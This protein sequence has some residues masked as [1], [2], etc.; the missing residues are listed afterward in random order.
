MEMSEDASRTQES[1]DGNGRNRK[2]VVNLRE[3]LVRFASDVLRQISKI[4]S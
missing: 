2:K 1:E 3:D 4:S